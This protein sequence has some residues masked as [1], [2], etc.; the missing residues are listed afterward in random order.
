MMGVNFC[1]CR[2]LEKEVT[3]P[4]RC[5]YIVRHTCLN[6]RHNMYIRSLIVHSTN[7]DMTCRIAVMWDDLT[8]KNTKVYSNT[9]SVI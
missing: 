6:T 8:V 5:V 1:R 2:V 4:K 7:T 9:Q 3:L